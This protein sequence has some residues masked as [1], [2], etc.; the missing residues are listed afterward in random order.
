MSGRSLGEAPLQVRG[1]YFAARFLAQTVQNVLLAGLFLAA[2]TSSSA[3]IDLSSVFV[4]ILIPAVFLGPLGGATVDRIG[5]PTGLF[6]GAIG[7]A[8]VAIGGFFYIING[9]SPW[10]IAFAYSAVSQIVAPHVNVDGPEVSAM[11][12][13]FEQKGTV[14]D[15]TWQLWLAGNP[16]QAGLGIPAAADSDANR[17]NAAYMRMLKRL[18]DAGVP[19]VPGTDGSS[20]NG[21]LELYERAGI[22]APEVL[23]I[24]TIVS[25]KAMGDDRD[26]GSIAPGME[27]D[28]VV[29]D[30]KS[31][32]IIDYRMQFARTFE[33]ALFIQMMLGDDRAVQATYV[34]GKLVHRRDREH[35]AIAV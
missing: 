11:I 17:I 18:F 19:L 16:Q 13:F 7:R 26:Y 31:T 33:Q 6:L 4:A 12:D 25:A 24:A 15:G 23:R 1:T 28:L 29:L 14:I 32:P 34:A 21:E 22:P 27:A 10:P 2:G 35:S 20:F 8:A 5:A 3:A 30:M 9:G